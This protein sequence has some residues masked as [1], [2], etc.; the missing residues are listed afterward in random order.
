MILII[1]RAIMLLHRKMEKWKAINELQRL[2]DRE[3][4]DI[5]ITRYD[6]D[7]NV[8]HNLNGN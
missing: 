3:L 5:G 7:Y 4:H 2:S 1:I 8:K 6:I